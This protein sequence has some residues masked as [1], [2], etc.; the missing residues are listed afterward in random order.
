MSAPHPDDVG[1]FA[2]HRRLCP[3]QLPVFM[4]TADESEEVSSFR[5]RPGHHPA[6]A[7]ERR[8]FDSAPIVSP[9]TSV[10]R[11]TLMQALDEKFIFTEFLKD[12]GVPYT[13][14]DGVYGVAEPERAAGVAAGAQPV[15]SLSP[16]PAGR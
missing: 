13:D 11:V 3:T 14:R 16:G 10:N 5:H 4:S 8:E 15:Q 7:N 9:V 12:H 1:F 6:L 2:P